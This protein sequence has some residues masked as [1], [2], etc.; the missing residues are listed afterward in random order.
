V[1]RRRD[2]HDDEAVPEDAEDQARTTADEICDRL[3]SA[4]PPVGALLED[5][6]FAAA[7]DRLAARSVPFEVVERLSRSTTSVLAA[8]AHRAA[9]LRDDTTDEWIDWAFRRLKSV[10]AGEAE[11]LL[12]AIERHVAPPLVA[13]VLA[14]ADKDWSEGWLLEV[15]T[16]FVERRVGAGERPSGADFAAAVGSD[17]VE[18]VGALIGRLDVLPAETVAEFERWRDERAQAAYFAQLGR[19]WD[20]GSRDPAV[21]TVGGRAAALEVL[22]GAV[23][24]G[25]S[26]LVVGEHGVGKSAVVYEALR[27]FVERGFLVVEAGAA[28]VVAGHHWVGQ[29]EGR[30]HEIEE[31]ATKGLPVVWVLPSFENTLWMGQHARSPRGLLDALL[32]AVAPGRLVVV[33]ELEPKAYE[34]L[35]QQRPQVGSAFETVRLE[36]LAQA[37]TLAVAR[38]WRDRSDADVDDAT[39]GSAYDLAEHYLAGIAAPA[40]VLRLLKAAVGDVRRA[41]GGAVRREQVI[42]TLSTLTGLPLHVV[43]PDAPLDLDEVRVYFSSRVLAQPDAV[44][45]IVDRIAL[46]K[47]NLTDPSRPLGVFLFVGPTGTGKTELA[48]T[49]AEFLFGSPDRL[50]RLDMTEFQTERGFERLLG[51]SSLEGDASTL[52]PSVRS[53]PF[54]V[55]LL[56]EFE[57]AHRNIWNVFLQLFD[58]GRLTDRKGVTADFRQCVV[59]L[60]SNTGAAVESGMPLGFTGGGGPRFR[61]DAVEKR[62][63]RVFNP[64][65]L[66][67]IDRV[68]VF[69]PF[70]RGQMRALLERELSLVLQRRGF[71][72]RPWAVEWDESALELLAERG[73][74][75][76]LGARPLKRA[77]ERYVL[78]PL[79][80]AIVS[81]SFPEGEQFLFIAARDGEI[82]VTFVDPDAEEEAAPGARPPTGL[83]LER[84]VLEPGGGVEAS[85]F[86]QAETERL[87]AILAG[88]GWHGSKEV[89]LEALQDEAFWASSERF[90]VLGRI[91]YVDR[92][93]AAFRTAEKLAGRLR[94]V[95]GKG[96]STA[97]DLVALLAGR[98]YILDRA[99]DGSDA[100]GPSDAYLEIRTAGVE[101]SERDFA[102]QLREMYELWARKRGMRLLPLWSERGDLFAVA[103][104]GAY[105]ILAGEHGLH[106][107]ELPERES[108]FERV[109]VHVTVA[110]R[111]PG[112]PDVDPLE[113]ARVALAAVEQTNSIVRRYRALPSPLVRDVVRDWR[114]GRL[115]RV[116]GG[117]FDVIGGEDRSPS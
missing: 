2:E 25:R 17:K 113:H 67:R 65:F 69:R 27:P 26:V 56:D 15:V 103:G 41:G 37:E 29:L 73:F 92:V 70:E 6:S 10:Y 3:E 77:V 9:S 78:A 16:A 109:A 59:I 107:H 102:A 61:P 89:D 19:V 51:D 104:I 97:R 96:R 11:F 79:A 31:H 99:C 91:E 115:D 4:Y 90:A 43:D 24:D 110:P 111:L 44:D 18:D 34:L 88:A 49:L 5:E 13:R 46:V 84:L 33:G 63:T 38:D 68:V 85:A 112:A 45:C 36:P 62:L 93:E 116:L 76:E 35:L 82:D 20:G 55:I 22:R 40:R 86:L 12:R 8:M 58:D 64:E 57:K 21:T 23:A 47:A 53:K 71:R 54:S 95:D 7:S 14:S 32:P 87:G 39:I 75:A 28:D 105:P 101:R 50:I 117:D 48:K 108:S 114:T 52:I 100:S 83:R 74:S 106:V 60:T 1:R 80:A 81:R 98:L 72:D 30:V 94:R 66:N 42:A